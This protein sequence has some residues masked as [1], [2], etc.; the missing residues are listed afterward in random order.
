MP[1][2]V[3][4]GLLLLAVLVVVEYHRRNG[5]IEHG[6]G[7]LVRESPVQTDA[8][9][10]AGPWQHADY[11][12]SALASLDIRGRVIG[13]TS[14]WSD[15]ESDLAPVDVGL[16]WG[17]LSDSAVLDRIEFTHGGRFLRYW[18]QE[19][20]VP[21]SELDSSV[22]N[23]HVIPSSD[24]I[25][26]RILAL[27]EGQ[28]VRLRGRLVEARASDGW[29]WRSSLVRTDTGFGAC[30]LMWVESVESL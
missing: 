6:P 16:G 4:V 19:F 27:R 5:A 28:T 23:I 29:K 18:V 20:P 10:D 15:R 14:Y 26:D 9:S 12:L 8:V 22:A 11:E 21:R 3:K 24:A 13:V 30:E 17:R 2:W 1:K 7:V 25:H